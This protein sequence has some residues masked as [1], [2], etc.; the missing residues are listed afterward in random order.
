MQLCALQQRLTHIIFASALHNGC[1]CTA[2]TAP[3]QHACGVAL[4]CWPSVRPSPGGGIR[5]GDTAAGTYMGKRAFRAPAMRDRPFPC[6]GGPPA[7]LVRSHPQSRHAPTPVRHCPCLPPLPTPW[8]PPVRTPLLRAFVHRAPAAT[9]G[10]SARSPLSPHAGGTCCWTLSLLKT[11]GPPRRLAA[12]AAAA[13]SPSGGCLR[14]CRAVRFSASVAAR[15]REVRQTLTLA[16]VERQ[17]E[18][19]MAKQQG[20]GMHALLMTPPPVYLRV[21]Y[22]ASTSP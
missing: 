14:G 4:R 1:R 9:R 21:R 8:L 7:S 2:P 10:S 19:P 13:L 6:S 20:C 15:R 12:A 17:G 18:G 11:C 5:T 22:R 16:A 3:P